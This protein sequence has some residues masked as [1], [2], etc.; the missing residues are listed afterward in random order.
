MNIIKEKSKNQAIDV[1]MIVRNGLFIALTYVFTKVINISL[2]ISS[3]GGLIHLG[4]IPLFIGAFVFGKRTGAIAGSFGMALFDITSP[5]AV[6][7]PFTF[8]IVGIMG[9][10]M[11]KITEK[12]LSFITAFI[13]IVASGFIKVIGYYIAEVIICHNW[14]TP[15]AAIPAN[16]IQIVVAGIIVLPLIAPMQR[17]KA[18]FGI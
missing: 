1:Q 4:N 10:A 5:W 15:A 8:I 6:W 7:A 18:Q 12:K 3:S 2:P 11:G 16:V 17:I 13:A 9:Y 14:F